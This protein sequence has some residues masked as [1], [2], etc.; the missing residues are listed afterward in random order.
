M[1]RGPNIKISL[2][3]LLE[4]LKTATKRLEPTSSPEP[5]KQ[6]MNEFIFALNKAGHIDNTTLKNVF[7][8]INPEFRNTKITV[9]TRTVP[10]WYPEEMGDNGLMWRDM[11]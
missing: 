4:V 8:E 2:T 10:Y 3:E 5:T 6:I 1:D 7:Q 11:R 9:A